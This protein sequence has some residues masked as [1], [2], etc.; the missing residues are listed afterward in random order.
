MLHT[1]RPL[2]TRSRCGQ[3]F[4]ASLLLGL[5]GSSSAESLTDAW[6]MALSAD[7]VQASIH[8]LRDA[9]DDEARATTRLRFPVVD[10][11]ASYTQMQ[12]AP[13]LDIETPAG[14]LQSPKIWPNDRYAMSSAELSVPLWTSGRISGLINAARAGVQRAAAEDTRGVADLKLGVAEAYVGVFRARAAEAVAESTVASLQAHAQDVEVMFNQEAVPKSDLLAAQVA[15]ANARQQQLRAQHGLRL[16]TSA[17]NRMVG[18]PMD[19]SPD[20]DPPAVPSRAAAVDGLAALVQLAL[21]SRPELAAL[22]AQQEAYAAQ[23]TAERAQTW[24]QIGLRMGVTH[25]DNQ[26]LDRQN[27]AS[28]GVGIQWRLFDSGQVSAR[29]SAWRHRAE[30]T[31]RLQDD[32][33]TRIEL[34]VESAWLDQDDAGARLRASAEAVAHAEENLRLSRELYAVGLATNAQVLDATAL[35][36]MAVTNRDGADYDSIIAAYRLSRAIGEL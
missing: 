10:L 18:Q 32:L 26:I 23:A 7:G 19:R 3:A 30:A 29:V 27:F 36:V 15:L 33:R 31:R 24:P 17:Y 1:T 5:A 28:V 11:S 9:A 6:H 34:E 16:A 22:G 25:L 14:R 4:L 13:F 21:R 8:S 20:L 2:E 12:A 35:R